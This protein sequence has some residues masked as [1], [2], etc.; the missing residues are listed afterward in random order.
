ME[1]QT[2]NFEVEFNK[3]LEDVD[4]IYQLK[5]IPKFKVTLK[6]TANSISNLLDIMIR[7]SL[8]K[9]D[10][11]NYDELKKDAFYLPEEKAF[12]EMDKSRIIYDRLKAV[13]NAFDYVASNIP[14]SLF[15]FTEEYLENCR[16]LLEYFSFHTLSSATNVNTRTL[17]ELTDRIINGNDEI[18]KKVVQDNL[19]LLN[20]SFISIRN[21]LEEITKFKKE[22][23]KATIRY[24]I[25]PKLPVDFTQKL[26][27]E[28]TKIYL[29]KA[30]DYMRINIPG[31]Q[32]YKLWL[33]ESFK[34]CYNNDNN[35]ALQKLKEQFISETDKVKSDAAAHSPREKLLKIV[36]SLAN[37]KKI[38]ESLYFDFD[39]NL[40]IINNREKSFV[41]KLQDILRKILNIADQSDF[42]HIEYLNPSTK[43]IQKD[44]INI[45]DFML[46]IKKKILLFSEILKANSNVAVKI[47]KGTEESLFN[48]LED[49]YINLLLMK[50]RI[51]GLDAELRLS[52]QKKLKNKLRNIAEPVKE[53]ETYLIK[54]GEQRR[55][56][57][58][59]QDDF[60]KQKKK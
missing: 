21:H 29:K 33:E 5:K 45:T 59:E 57:I 15:E 22:E 50:E 36:Y 44:I 23:F 28:N 31:V 55:R 39:Y 7:K 51:I 11:Y 40:K 19:K 46:M 10:I 41:E 13:I 56:Y 26:F 6:G 16:K 14:E 47:N 30:E 34:D 49:S 54:I 20:D 24:E 18:F 53:L 4:G 48:F 60:L 37:S 9:E 32:I 35:A 17:K 8:V 3:I 1:N 58:I 27:N 12:Q 43:T 52:L 42:Y 2:E 38:I 25:F